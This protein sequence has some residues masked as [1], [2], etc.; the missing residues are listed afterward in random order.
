M[1]KLLPLAFEF[2]R[3]SPM[4]DHPGLVEVHGRRG[5]RDVPLK[6]D[7][8]GSAG[9]VGTAFLGSW[10]QG[11]ANEGVARLFLVG[12]FVVISLSR[13]SPTKPAFFYSAQQLNFSGS[14]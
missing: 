10:L 6:P 7:R 8:P 14:L 1:K 9:R 11:R 12:L 5:Y 4:A 13:G 3:S 2:L